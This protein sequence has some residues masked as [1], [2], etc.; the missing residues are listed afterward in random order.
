MFKKTLISLIIP[1]VLYSGLRKNDFS[2]IAFI[3]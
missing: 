1:V 2:K 3:V